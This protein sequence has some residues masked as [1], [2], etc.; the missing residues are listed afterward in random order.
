MKV[1]EK[2][3][4]TRAGASEYL[5]ERWGIIRAPSTL[6]KLACVGGGPQYR[7]AGQAA[8]YDEADLD[9]WAAALL[10]KPPGG[11]RAA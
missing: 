9:A 5:R 3:F 2:P 8:L 6:T 4:R 10:A 11:S 7:R 1:P